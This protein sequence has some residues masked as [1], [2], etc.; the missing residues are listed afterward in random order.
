MTHSGRGIFR[1][2]SNPAGQLTVTY[3]A[4]PANQDGGFHPT[5]TVSRAGIEETL[6]S[7]EIVMGWLPAIAQAKQLAQ[8][9]E[10]HGH[11]K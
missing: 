6:I 2:G 10:A 8:R 9:V 11:A 3:S 7:R 4:I 1:R 5:V